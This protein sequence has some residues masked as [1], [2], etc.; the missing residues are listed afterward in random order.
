VSHTR[1]RVWPEMAFFSPVRP[2]RDRRDKSVSSPATRIAQQRLSRCDDRCTQMRAMSPERFDRRQMEASRAGQNETES[3]S[4]GGWFAEQADLVDTREKA[5]GALHE[6]DRIDQDALWRTGKM[7]MMGAEYRSRYG[8]WYNA[9]SQPSS[10]N[11]M[12]SPTKQKL[13]ANPPFATDAE[14]LPLTV[15]PPPT[16]EEDIHKYGAFKAGNQVLRGW[17]GPVL[18]PQAEKDVANYNYKT[19][20][21]KAPKVN[22]KHLENHF[23]GGTLEL[24]DLESDI[25]EHTGCK[26]VKSSVASHFVGGRMEMNKLDMEAGGGKAHVE[27]RATFDHLE[28][29]FRNE[30]DF[31]TSDFYQQKGIAHSH[32]AQ[33]DHFNFGGMTMDES[34][35]D[36]FGG[37]LDGAHRKDVE[38]HLNKTADHFKGMALDHSQVPEEDFL[39]SAQGV[40]CQTLNKCSSASNVK[41]AHFTD[42]GMCM[43][44]GGEGLISADGVYFKAHTHDPSK[45]S[46]TADHFD[47]GFQ[48]SNSTEGHVDMISAFGT[49]MSHMKSV[50]DHHKSEDHFE[51][52]GFN[53]DESADSGLLDI[54]GHIVN[55]KSKVTGHGAV[56]VQSHFIEGGMA[57]SA[58]KNDDVLVSADGSLLHG[59]KHNLQSRSQDH[60]EGMR[61]DSGV[62]DIGLLSAFGGCAGS[63]AHVEGRQMSDDHMQ[64]GSMN[65]DASVKAGLMSAGGTELQGLHHMRGHGRQDDHF[66]RAGNASGFTVQQSAGE[67]G[68]YRNKHFNS[69]Y[70]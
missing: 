20:S 47:G 33:M 70:S 14:V 56:D 21:A 19:I 66:N 3:F 22:A 27:A 60:F 41:D 67:K 68:A 49:Q 46:K 35:G 23:V 13:Y 10:P 69:F 40:K 42:G 9:P 5:F 28:Q 61:M 51:R 15:R 53:L 26:H 39:M 25:K 7:G 58:A 8:S 17:I 64:G 16:N 44:S 50:G 1:S 55:A 62:E 59:M 24:H 4:Y 12:G 11:K 37:M 48:L 6:H 54:T 29:H 45:P 52:E 43:K 65:L 38:G 63:V 36:G 2:A 34:A 18:A 31:A 57:L 32:A 30:D